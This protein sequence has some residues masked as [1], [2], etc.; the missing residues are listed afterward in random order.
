MALEKSAQQP[1]EES[2]PEQQPIPDDQKDQLDPET[3]P[4]A[5]FDEMRL[6]PQDPGLDK[7]RV[8]QLAS[9]MCTEE[10]AAAFFG[11]HVDVIK[12][13]YMSEMISGWDRGK[14][15]LRQWQMDRAKNGDAEMLKWLGKQFLGQGDYK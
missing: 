7:A 2:T 1:V 12:Y 8:V 11:V 5:A 3:D 4:A 9:I 13:H 10:Q 15:Q 6:Y 14:I